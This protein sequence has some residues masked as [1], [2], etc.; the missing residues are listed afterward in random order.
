MAKGEKTCPQCKQKTGPR[1]IQ[2]KQC[3]FKFEIKHTTKKNSPETIDIKNSPG[4]PT[5][6]NLVY[7]PGQNIK[8]HP[9]CPIKPAGNSEKEMIEWIDK[10]QDYIFDSCGQKTKYARVAIKYFADHYWPMYILSSSEKE[11]ITNPLYT[12]AIKLIEEN[13][14]P[15][16][17]ESVMGYV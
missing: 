10:L 1:T 5:T 11:L 14:E 7:T 4:T 12:Q 15:Y 17:R 2:C 6:F 3:S 16:Q 8:G 9:F 13:M